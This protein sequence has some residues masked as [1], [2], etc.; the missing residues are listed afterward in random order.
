M[1]DSIDKSIISEHQFEYFFRTN[2]FPS[3][4]WKVIENDLILIDY[5]DSV[6]TE[7]YCQKENLLGFKASKIYKDQKDFF[8]GLFRCAFSKGIVS[9]EIKFINKITGEEEVMFVNYRFLPPDF[10]LVHTEDITNRKKTE[11]NIRN[12][13]ISNLLFYILFT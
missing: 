4:I 9:K 10:V 6:E 7:T 8:E 13:D 5:N 3:Y 1:S 2:P 12:R 11:R